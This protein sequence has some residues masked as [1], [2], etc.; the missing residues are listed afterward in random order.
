[1]DFPGGSDGKALVCNEETWVDPWA[2]NIPW[3][4]AGRPTPAGRPPQP[5]EPEGLKSMGL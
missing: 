5:E 1:M 4:R 3:R 2:G